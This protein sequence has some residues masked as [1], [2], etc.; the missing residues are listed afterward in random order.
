MITRPGV[1]FNCTRMLRIAR[2]VFEGGEITAKWIM[3]E[4]GVSWSTAKKDMQLVG[5]YLPVEIEKPARW[6]GQDPRAKR[7][8]LPNR[9]GM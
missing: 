1:V 3:G 7:L 4:F 5:M 2:H 8:R 6:P 9:G